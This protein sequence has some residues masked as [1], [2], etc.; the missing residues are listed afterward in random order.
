MPDPTPDAALVGD[1]L[2]RGRRDRT[3][4]LYAA[5]RDR[6]LSYR[7]VCTTAYKV[8]NVLSHH[9]VRAGD[10]VAVESRSRPEPV[11]TFLGTVMLGAVTEFSA[12]PGTDARA[13]VVPADREGEFDLP[14]GSRLVAFAAKPERATTTHWEAEVWSENPAFPPTDHDPAD[15]VLASGPPDADGERFSHRDLL[16]LARDAAT[17]LALDA[18]SRV[19]L[20]APLSSPRAV[21]AGVLA[22]L[23][24][25]GC[26]VLPDGDGGMG[27][28]AATAAVVDGG[29]G[30]EAAEP[31][32]YR[33]TGV[34][35]RRSHN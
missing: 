29:D 13:A 5:A 28:S 21:A 24:V 35:G 34:G 9:G 14:P 22:P 19:A 31:A 25:G 30:G 6:T 26:V 27:E 18:D 7:D 23:L 11:L 4:A 2:A 17:E 33:T 15:P 12:E 32:V 8:G 3:P 16:S 20:R 10:R 1:L